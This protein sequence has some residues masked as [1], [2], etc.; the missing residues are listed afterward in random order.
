MPKT[1]SP[2]KMKNKQ[3]TIE[4]KSTGAMMQNVTQS[5]RTKDKGQDI[6][7][8]LRIPRP[9]GITTLSLQLQKTQDPQEYKKR[10]NHIIRVITEQWTNTN[11][12]LNNKL[13]SINELATYLNTN[14]S[15]ITKYMYKA[16]EKVGNFFDGDKGKEFTR[17][18]FANSLKKSLEF[19]ALTVGQAEMLIKDQDG[20]YTPFLSSEVNRSIT[21]VLNSQKPV[22]DLLSLLMD[23]K[24]SNTILNLNI[25][26]NHTN[27]LHVTNEQALR[28]INK[29]APSMLNDPHLADAQVE[30]YRLAGLLPD[31]NARS[32]DLTA[33]GIRHKGNKVP[34]IPSNPIPNPAKSP[35]NPDKSQ[36][37]IRQRNSGII[38]VL[39]AKDFQA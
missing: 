5:K 22:L 15:T 24:S 16:M 3:M 19:Q 30:K 27:E 21:N 14:E 10:K 8:G 32:Q 18:L 12:Q 4:D 35:S 38:E 34:E 13:C 23:T 29:E 26:N 9:T 20:H 36:E 1:I 31:V 37:R 17:V 39:E 28:I 11:M 33:I 25:Q 2:T 6:K 7:K